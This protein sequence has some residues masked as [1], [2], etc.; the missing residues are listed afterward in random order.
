MTGKAAKLLEESLNAKGV[1]FDKA[2]E[3]VEDKEDA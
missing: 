2:I 3:R 1:D